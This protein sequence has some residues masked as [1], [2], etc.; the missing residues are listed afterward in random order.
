MTAQQS[1]T[2]IGEDGCDTAVSRALACNIENVET[3]P[4]V[5]GFLTSASGQFSASFGDDGFFVDDGTGGVFV[6]ITGSNQ[7]GVD[8]LAVG[9][10]VSITGGSTACLY[11]TLALE[12][13]TIGILDDPVEL[14]PLAVFKPKQIGQLEKIPSIPNYYVNERDI[15]NVCNCLEPKSYTRG[16]LITVRGTMIGDLSDEGQWGWK[17]FLGDGTG[18]AQVFIDGEIGRAHV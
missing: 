4:L 3:Y 16:R 7:T 8:E 14:S 2:C 9:S 5:Q 15:G 1:I 18:I 10:H 13:G 12:G 17:L 11:G 6:S